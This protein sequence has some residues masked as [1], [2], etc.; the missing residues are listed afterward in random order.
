[1]KLSIQD[2]AVVSMSKVCSCLKRFKLLNG[3]ESNDIVSTCIFGSLLTKLI[4]IEPDLHHA[5]K[6]VFSFDVVSL[7]SKPEQRNQY[8]EALSDRFQRIQKAEENAIP[9]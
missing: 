4:E 5:L 6:S 1:M 2:L 9:Y 3:Q 8:I 7:H